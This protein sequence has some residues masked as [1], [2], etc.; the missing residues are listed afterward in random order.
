MSDAGDRKRTIL[1]VDDVSVDRKLLSRCLERDG[2][3]VSMAYDGRQ[4]LQLLRAQQDIALVRALRLVPPRGGAHP[5]RPARPCAICGALCSFLA[6]A[7]AWVWRRLIVLLFLGPRCG[8][9]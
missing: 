5:P 2:Y 9:F 1:V 8:R 7:R 6:H 4:A 3:G